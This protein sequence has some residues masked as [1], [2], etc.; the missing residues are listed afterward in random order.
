M[1][2]SHSG[3]FLSPRRP[4]P[5]RAVLEVL[6]LAIDEDHRTKSYG[7]PSRGRRSHPQAPLYVSIT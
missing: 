1:A 7:R 4:Q 6:F 5:P 3:R 2:T